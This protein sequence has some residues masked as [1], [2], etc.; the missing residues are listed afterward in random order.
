MYVSVYAQVKKNVLFFTI[1]YTFCNIYH[2]LHKFLKLD[3]LFRN[4]W[5]WKTFKK[6]AVA[7]SVENLGY[8][9]DDRGSFLCGENN[10][11]FSLRHR[12]HTGSGAH[13]ASSPMGTGVPYPKGK[14][15][16]S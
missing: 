12:V 7:L 8:G 13:P 1:L 2:S 6:S 5:N 10:E 11:N 3:N 9:L 16:E 4:F 15:T 14:A